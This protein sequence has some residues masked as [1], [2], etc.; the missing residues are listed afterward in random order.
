MS[1]GW[2][3][4]RARS[5][6]RCSAPNDTRLRPFRTCHALPCSTTCTCTV[7]LGTW[8]LGEGLWMGS[9]GKSGGDAATRP[10]AARRYPDP[11]PRRRRCAPHPRWSL[12]RLRVGREA[13]CRVPGQAGARCIPSLGA[14]CQGGGGDGKRHK[15]DQ[16]D[17]GDVSYFYLWDY[18][19]ISGGVK[20]AGIL[21]TRAAGAAAEGRK[22]GPRVDDAAVGRSSAPR[23]RIAKTNCRRPRHL[24]RHMRREGI[25]YRCVA[26]RARGI[27]GV[28]RPSPRLRRTR[29]RA[30]L[31]C[32]RLMVA[33]SADRPGSGPTDSS[34]THDALD[35]IDDGRL[36]RP[37]CG[38]ARAPL[39]RRG[40]RRLAGWAFLVLFVSASL[41]VVGPACRG[42]GCDVAYGDGDATMTFWQDRT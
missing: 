40:F 23:K 20:D 2:Q 39:G 13:R 5:D 26:W 9:S 4:C 29:T 22:I 19:V 25:D 32:D 38:A 41:C 37:A 30:L 16:G 11:A 17:L 15:V 31:Q 24:G 42:Q 18:G 3:G 10:A 33:V 12:G 27:G 14:C 21:A 34:P 8:H 28:R 35:R 36:C 7:P 6:S 1:P